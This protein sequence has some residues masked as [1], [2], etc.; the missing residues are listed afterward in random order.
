MSNHEISIFPL[1]APFLIPGIRATQGM[2]FEELLRYHLCQ[3]E[4]LP[5]ES[6]KIAYYWLHPC[7]K[8]LILKTIDLFETTEGEIAPESSLGALGK[9][10]FSEFWDRRMQEFED[11]SLSKAQ[12]SQLRIEWELENIVLALDL[13]TSTKEA[14]TRTSEIVRVLGQFAKTTS[15]ENREYRAVLNCLERFT[16]NYK[17]LINSTA[18]R[19]WAV[20]QLIPF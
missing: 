11:G 13:W 16:S 15:L 12:A 14:E 4:Y 3:V 2:L 18:E 10:A 20:L 7:L 1:F 8:L 17:A 5:T 19:Q 9:A 6:E